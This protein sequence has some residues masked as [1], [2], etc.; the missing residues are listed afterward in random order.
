MPE[1]REPAREL[2]PEYLFWVSITGREAEGLHAVIMA[3]VPDR[4]DLLFYEVLCGA[5]GKFIVKP[6]EGELKCEIC[7]RERRAVFLAP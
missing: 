5:K 1:E 6:W 7:E 3:H 4:D 2:D